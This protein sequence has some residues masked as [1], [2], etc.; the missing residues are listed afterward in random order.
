MKKR[1]HFNKEKRMIR[2]IIKWVSIA[3]ASL[4]VLA[5]AFTAVFILIP[6]ARTAR[7]L[8]EKYAEQEPV[9]TQ[10][11]APQTAE[12]T[13]PAQ[14]ETTQPAQTPAPASEATP[15]AAQTEYDIY[16]S[17]TF[18][19]TGSVTDSSGVTNPMEMA[20]T[21]DSIYMLTSVSD[22][23]MGVMIG[24]GKTYLVSPENRAYIELSGAVMSMLGMD[25]TKL[26]AP[27]NFNFSD[28]P[29]LSAAGNVKETE[30]DGVACKEYEFT[31]QS[32]KQTRVYMADT[33]LLQ[34][35]IL[36]E[37]GTLVNRMAF[38]S[39]SG[40]IPSDRIAPPTY[41]EKKGLLAFISMMSKSMNGN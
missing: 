38:D 35:D 17:G 27:S 19:V 28:M 6:F 8:S 20:V 34:I 18:Y 24:G 3:L 30:L 4:L 31:A 21:E 26:S 23:K 41:Y 14:P 22:V 15:A 1:L 12:T 33:R 37:D 7:N 29:D 16:R 5:V 39:V 40:Q 13:A 2:K 25:S 9:V 32:G 36:A 10:Q 11:S